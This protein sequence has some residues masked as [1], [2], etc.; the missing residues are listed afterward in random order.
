MPFGA[1][2]AGGASRRFG[3]PKALATVGGVRLVERVRDAI[4][5][6]GLEPRLITGH[7][8]WFG[9]LGIASRP[10]YFPGAGPLAGI[11]A[12]LTWARE[13]SRPGVVCL[14]CDLPFVPPGLLRE[15][16]TS[17]G[18]TLVIPESCSPAGIEPLCAY[19]PVEC[20]SEVALRLRRGEHRMFD[21]LAALPVR[22]VALADVRRWG[23]PE[24]IFFNVNTPAD[25][26]RA[27]H[28]AQG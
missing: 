1:I 26:R 12:A 23:E 10:D 3:T 24:R 18:D 22:R 25:H 7:P 5:Q 11:H 28:L 19:Y 8:D 21:L 9:D 4:R 6:A 20:L 13:E 27:E 16:C 17:A 2:L 14:S 15:L